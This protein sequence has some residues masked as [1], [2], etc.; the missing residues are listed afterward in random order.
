MFDLVN[1]WPFGFD[2]VLKN[3]FIQFK[4]VDEV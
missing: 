3:S 2:V 1:P 4:D